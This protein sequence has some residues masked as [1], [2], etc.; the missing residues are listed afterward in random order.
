MGCGTFVAG[1]LAAKR[2]EEWEEGEGKW[3]VKEESRLNLQI[4]WPPTT[5]LYLSVKLLSQFPL[6]LVR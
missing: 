1:L 4:T 5:T 2:E 6:V 3:G